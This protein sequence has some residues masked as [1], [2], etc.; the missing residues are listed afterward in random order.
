MPYSLVGRFAEE[1]GTDGGYSEAFIIAWF[2]L[3]LLGPF[4][5]VI[6]TRFLVPE[7]T[8][9]WR[10]LISA[11]IAVPFHLAL[12]LCQLYLGFLPF[13]FLSA[14]GGSLAMAV[15]PFFAIEYDSDHL[16]TQALL[17]FVAF[18]SAMLAFGFYRFDLSSKFDAAASLS[19]SK[20]KL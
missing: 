3:L 8:S 11:I 9:I 10:S 6:A 18:G 5:V 1:G 17:A 14:I 16:G 4:L 13:V 19:S 20:I 15:I 7:R 12:F 2:T